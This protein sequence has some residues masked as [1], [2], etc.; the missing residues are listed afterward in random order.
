MDVG[1]LCWNLNRRPLEDLV[2]ELAHS[3]RVDVVI[4]LECTTP[5]AEILNALGSACGT[6]FH[7]ADS[8]VRMKTIRV[9]TRFSSQFVHPVAE[10]PRYSIRRL[11][12]PA[13][14]ELLLAMVHLPSKLH[15]SEDSQ[16]IECTELARTISAAEE[17]IG[18]SRTVLVGDLNMN[19]FEKGVVGAGGLNAVSSRGVA[20]RNRRRVQGRDYPYFYNPMWHCLGERDGSTPGTYYY[21]S[22]EHVTYYWHMF[23]QVI[24]RP[25]LVDR[26]RLDRIEIVERIGAVS[27]LDAKGLPDRAI[28]SDHLPLLFSMRL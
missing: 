15:R 8:P 22:G 23:D 2:A 10:G 20:L 24:V 17:R 18:H 12:L 26:L 4:L 27:L 19:P 28:A 16:V 1:F 5:T 3:R 6:L 25:E 9:F 11:A 7:H 21:D 14:D 13:T